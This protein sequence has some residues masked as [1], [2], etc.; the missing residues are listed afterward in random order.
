M[1]EIKE[2]EVD[3]K[4]ENWLEKNEERNWKFAEKTLLGCLRSYE[5]I[6]DLWSS[7]SFDIFRW[8]WVAGYEQAMR[9]LGIHY[10]TSYTEEVPDY[11]DVMT[12]ENF[13]KCC[14]IGG[15]ID[16]DGEGFPIKDGKVAHDCFVKPSRRALLPKDATH[17]IWFNK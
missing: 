17:V 4:A 5:F 12:V 2:E 11:G 10:S 14:E 16:S 13:I 3:L 7:F 15:F 1:H 8:I 9:D 6:G